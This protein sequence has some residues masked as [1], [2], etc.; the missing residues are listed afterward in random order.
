MSTYPGTSAEDRQ[1]RYVPPLA[2]QAL[3]ASGPQAS[4]SAVSWGAIFAGA[5]AAA[6]L[7]LILLLLGTGLGLSALSPWSSRGASAEAFGISAIVWIAVTQVMASGMGGYLAGRLRT[8]WVSVHT[9]EVYFRDT[10]H[11]FLSWAL[12]SLVTAAVLSSVTGAIVGQ[13]VQAGAAAVGTA[14]AGAAAMAATSSTGSAVSSSPRADAPATSGNGVDGYFMDSLFRKDISA[15]AASGP[16]TAATAV[17]PA[18]SP[19]ADTPAAIAASTAEAGRIY[20]NDLRAGAMPPED[21]RYVGQ[22]VAQ[23]AGLSQPDAEKRVNEGFARMQTKLREAQVATRDAADKAR[24]ASIYGT[25]WMFVS[26]LL[27]AFVASLA[28]TFG[29]RERDMQMHSQST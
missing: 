22:M 25:L 3:I 18:A 27:G 12:A 9:D 7:S 28:A 4:A 13:G 26:L 17:T 19:S 14:T 15:A 6:A 16:G 23:R 11:G 5:T 29:G 8:K 10:A 21:V 20:V 2:A 24:K 1:A